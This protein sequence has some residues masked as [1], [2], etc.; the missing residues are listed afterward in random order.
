MTLQGT[1]SFALVPQAD[2]DC[3]DDPDFSIEAALGRSRIAGI[4]EAGRGPW[5]GPVVAAAV[6]FRA[7]NCPQG[8]NDSKLLTAEVR[9][10]LYDEIAACADVG[11]GMADEEEIARNNLLGATFHAMQRALAAL[12]RPP[13]A[14]I[15]DGPH[16]PALPCHAHAVVKGDRRSLSIAAASI[17]AKVTR[18]RLMVELAGKF[19]GY[20]WERNKGYGSPE[21]AEGIARLGVSPHHRLSF[22]PVQ[23]LLSQNGT[24][25]LFD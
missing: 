5:A 6:V 2:K 10:H 21:H 20:G 25:T 13:H 12:R 22:K 3:P 14:A 23:A 18:D 1:N 8:L 7:G 15:V 19:P 9:S 16:A 11:I 4:D 17:V 24:R